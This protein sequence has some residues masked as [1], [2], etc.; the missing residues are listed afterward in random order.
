MLKNFNKNGYHIERNIF[1]KILQ[2][3]I[4]FAFYDI[5]HSIKKEIIL[6]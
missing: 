5:A 6:I 1:P 3:D 2:K 4:F